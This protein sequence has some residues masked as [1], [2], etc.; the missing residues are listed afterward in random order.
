MSIKQIS[1]NQEHSMHNSYIQGRP[2]QHSAIATHSEDE[3][4]PL[5]QVPG[6]ARSKPVFAQTHTAM[7][8]YVKLSH[9]C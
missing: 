5:L 8:G 1:G 4:V 9:P 7:L 6:L 2:I 3:E